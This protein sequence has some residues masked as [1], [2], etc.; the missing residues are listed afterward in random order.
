MSVHWC[1]TAEATI[2]EYGKASIF[3]KKVW[4]EELYWYLDALSPVHGP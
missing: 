1:R 4:W 3:K 2:T